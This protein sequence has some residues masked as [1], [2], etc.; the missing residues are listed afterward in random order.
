MCLQ[1]LSVYMDVDVKNYCLD[2]LFFVAFVW[3][4]ATFAVVFYGVDSVDRDA[5]VDL[6]D[7][8]N[9]QWIHVSQCSQTLC[10]NHLLFM[11]LILLNRAQ[12]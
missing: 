4:C 8:K 9:F 2:V 3:G 5:G 12:G 10:S 7:T 1:V 11:W 6:N